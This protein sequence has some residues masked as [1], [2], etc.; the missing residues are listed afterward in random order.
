MDIETNFIFFWGEKLEADSKGVK[1]F[2][3]TK[4]DF[5]KFR[6]KNNQYVINFQLEDES[7]YMSYKG[8]LFCKL[9]HKKLFSYIF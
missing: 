5:K 1:I 3:R 8:F 7:H 6:N 2:C 9:F 4:D